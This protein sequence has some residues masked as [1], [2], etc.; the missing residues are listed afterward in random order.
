MANICSNVIELSGNYKAFI[1]QLRKHNWVDGF[2]LVGPEGSSGYIFDFHEIT[3]TIFGF[4]SKWAP[5]ID[6]LALRAKKGR[7]SF[8]LEYEELGMGIFGKAFFDKENGLR[9]YDLP[10]ETLDRRDWNED[11]KLYID[12]VEFESDLEWLEEELELFIKNSQNG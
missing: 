12:G 10:Q 3:D 2:E 5:P 9:I 7:F 11:G 1:K 8:I 4:E 6:E